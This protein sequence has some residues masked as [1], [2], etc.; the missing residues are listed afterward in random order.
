MRASANAGG[1]LSGL[2]AQQTDLFQRVKDRA[3]DGG[4]S[5]GPGVQIYRRSRAERLL[6]CFVDEFPRVRVLLGD[7]AFRAAVAACLSAHP[8]KDPSMRR[9]GP[10]F[11]AFLEAEGFA[12]GVV[13]LARLE[14]AWSEVFDSSNRA[15]MSV[16]DLAAIPPHHWPHLAF[17]WCPD[18]QLLQF[19]T[20][21]D[22]FSL[23]VPRS[24]EPEPS[25]V[26]IYRKEFRI[27]IRRL[28]P[29]EAAALSILRTGVTLAEA[30][31]QL[32]GEPGPWVGWLNSWAEHG[33][34]RALNHRSQAEA[35][36]E[37]PHPD[38]R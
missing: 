24:P 29:A 8:P 38:V 6:A 27:F 26:L 37:S 14:V 18:H 10:C 33:L 36:S 2:L 30:M 21:V 31:G 25:E 35:P 22:G 1:R 34:I 12:D 13:D 16:A 7:E 19:R 28:D 17:Q 15:S 32:G 11:P 4:T 9:L 23:Q 5:L 20:R 3:D